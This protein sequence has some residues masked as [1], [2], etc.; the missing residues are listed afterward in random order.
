M[1]GAWPEAPCSEQRY[2]HVMEEC[3]ALNLVGFSQDY[4]PQLYLSSLLRARLHFCKF[5]FYSHKFPL[6]PINSH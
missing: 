1:Q 3:I 4:F 6:T 2:V 5:L